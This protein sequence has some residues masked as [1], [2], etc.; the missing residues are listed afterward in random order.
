MIL[1]VQF[2]YDVKTNLQSYFI[3]LS[4]SVLFLWHPHSNLYCWSESNQIFDKNTV[5]FLKVNNVYVCIYLFIKYYKYIERGIIIKSLDALDFIY[6][7][8]V[9][10]M[11]HISFIWLHF[12]FDKYLYFVSFTFVCTIHPLLKSSSSI[13]IINKGIQCPNYVYYLCMC[14]IFRSPF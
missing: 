8:M 6:N 11:L 3:I 2:L 14:N 13:N 12:H 4:L 7:F 10:I 1:S 5:M 9:I